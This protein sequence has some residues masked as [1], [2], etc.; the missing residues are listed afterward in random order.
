V[1]SPRLEAAPA[2]LHAWA[3]RRRW[4]AIGATL[5]CLVPVIVAIVRIAGRDLV[6]LPDTS[7]IDLHVRDVFTGDVPL[8][9]PY[10][11]FRW[12]HPGPLFY[13]ALAPL[14]VLGDTAPWTTLV[15]NTLLHGAVIVLVARLAWRRGGLTL[16][17]LVLGALTLSDA[18]IGTRLLLD[19]WNPNLAVPLF[20]LFVLQ[21]WS[22]AVGEHW[23]IAGAAVVGTFVIETHAGY[24]PFV[25][26]GAVWAI[27]LLMV[28]VRGGRAQW[29]D[30][31]APL[32]VGAGA[33][34]LL[35][36]PPLVD[37]MISDPGN[38]TLIQRYLTDGDGAR[39]GFGDAA[40]LVAGQ[41]RALPPWL[42]PDAT[43]DHVTALPD[44]ASSAWL[45]IPAA[46]VVVGIVAAR[47]I[48][49]TGAARFVA[50]MA[51]LV[52][53]GIVTAARVELPR[54]TYLFDW[55]VV[56]A[57]MLVVSVGWAL[58]LVAVDA[59]W[60]ALRVAGAA[61]AGMVLVWAAVGY[62]IDIAD[63]PLAEAAL[64]STTRRFVPA[65]ERAAGDDKILMRDASTKLSGL[66]DGLVDRLD[67]EGVD[68][69]VDPQLAF[70][71]G[72]H[73]TI[74]VHEASSVWHVSDDGLTTSVLSGAQGARVLASTSPLRPKAEGE[75]RT[76]QRDLTRHL[77]AAGRDG[78]VGSLDNSRSIGS[79]VNVPG[80]D[81][82]DV[83]R[84]RHLDRVVE[85]SGRCRCAVVAIPP[86]SPFVQ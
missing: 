76:L 6:L 38:L 83:A 64:A 44:I 17:L 32:V 85:A 47:R 1:P 13:Y 2:S 84:A 51:L 55:R 42:L 16:L 49:S 29:R 24:A 65:L 7:V 25:V 86:D 67:R 9:G 56:L 23:H 39:V 74:S 45:L 58:A 41:F 66:F 69:R 82:R 30:L 57:T 72:K 52:A 4:V 34:A 36:T 81:V 78:L 53:V 60:R 37:E 46:L 59:R 14:N 10:S 12:N 11:R 28:D 3:R 31:R 68:V 19:A 71:Y 43:H 62:S 20:V 77:R 18:A 48:G 26:A 80:I 63:A 79:I 75:L 15:A 73:R 8:V 35:W 40:G 50:L 54:F 5:V 70:V 33:A 21:L 27:A 22:I 61:L